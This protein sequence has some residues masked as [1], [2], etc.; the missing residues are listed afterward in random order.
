VIEQEEI[1]GLTPAPSEAITNTHVPDCGT[2]REDQWVDPG[3]LYDEG[4][5]NGLTLA[6]SEAITHT[7]VPD[8]GTQRGDQWVDLFTLYGS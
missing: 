1:S 4:G 2:Q 3:A 7:P 8:C 5:I 6:P